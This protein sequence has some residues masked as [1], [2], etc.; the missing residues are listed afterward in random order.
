MSPFDKD[1]VLG[2]KIE[3]FDISKGKIVGL[4]PSIR[5]KLTTHS[6]TGPLKICFPTDSYYCI[7]KNAFNHKC[8]YHVSSIDI[9]E[10]DIHDIDVG[11]FKNV[12]CENKNFSEINLSNNCLCLIE[13]CSF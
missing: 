2:S 11:A 3:H 7:G 5:L 13:K 4:S 6:Y 10:V 8:L 9:S 1:F 12:G